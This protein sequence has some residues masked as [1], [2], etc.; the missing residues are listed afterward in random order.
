MKKQEIG[1]H[2]FKKAVKWYISWDE[3]ELADWNFR[4]VVVNMFKGLKENIDIIIEDMGNLC[5]ETET[6]K[7]KQRGILELKTQCLKNFMARLNSIL[8]SAKERVWKLKERL[9]FNWKTNKKNDLKN[10]EPQWP[11]GQFIL[12]NI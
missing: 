6:M 8:E 2:H 12:D 10:L 3:S 9:L 1:T 4:I 7:D 5:R 11:V